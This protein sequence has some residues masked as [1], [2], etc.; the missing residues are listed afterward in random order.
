MG[1]KM[2]N[3][4]PLYAVVATEK[5]R[6]L[7][8]K[9]RK[10]KTKADFVKRSAASMVGH[11]GR[12]A[13]KLWET[14]DVESSE[15]DK[16]E[17][18]KRY[19]EEGAFLAGKIPDTGALFLG[20][21]KRHDIFASSSTEATQSVLDDSK[22]HL[23][24]ASVLVDAKDG[25]RWISV[26]HRR[27]SEIDAKQLDIDIADKVSQSEGRN[28]IVLSPTIIVRVSDRTEKQWLKDKRKQRS[29]KRKRNRR[30]RK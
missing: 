17:F 18:V 16:A 2:S 11:A 15:I 7:S 1:R 9:D 29:R 27:A 30:K 10:G 19:V 21:Y 24:Y 5:W 25:P 13:K 12:V 6:T 22:S 23:Y 14:R 20:E 28:A 26:R 4:N 3:H 8:P